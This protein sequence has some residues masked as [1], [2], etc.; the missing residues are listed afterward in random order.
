MSDFIRD[1][2]SQLPEQWREFAKLGAIEVGALTISRT[3]LS[4]N[5]AARENIIKQERAKLRSPAARAKSVLRPLLR[6]LV[7][8]ESVWESGMRS[9]RMLVDEENVIFRSGDHSRD[10][11]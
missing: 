5:F 2:Q 7:L 1:W 4:Q 11:I 8:A 3:V 6:R 9:F 10:D